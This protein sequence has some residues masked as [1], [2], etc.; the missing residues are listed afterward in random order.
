M[1]TRLLY[2]DIDGVLLGKTKPDDMEVILAKHV[3]EFLEFCLQRYKCYWLTTHCREEDTTTVINLLKRYAD[4]SVMEL[5]RAVNSTSW[6]TLKTEAIDFQSD[7]YW[8]D[9]QLLQSEIEVLKKNNA[10]N[11]WI[12]VDTRRNPD[13]LKRV[14]PIL[15]ETRR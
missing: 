8:L 5:I 2:L 4:E 15:Q 7:F 11:R 13:D 12:Q 14:I 6:K 10:F 1:S 9:D 3:K